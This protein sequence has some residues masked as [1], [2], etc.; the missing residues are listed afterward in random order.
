M[1]Q[2][3]IWRLQVQNIGQFASEQGE[4]DSCLNEVPKPCKRQNYPRDPWRP[5][6][7]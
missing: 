7:I 4:L 1:Q 3:G 6:S 2:C 5:I